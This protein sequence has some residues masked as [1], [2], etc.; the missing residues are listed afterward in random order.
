MPGDTGGVQ[1][2]TSGPPY[3]L[4]ILGQPLNGG[5]RGGVP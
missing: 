2:G 5:S 3:P 1:C 4:R